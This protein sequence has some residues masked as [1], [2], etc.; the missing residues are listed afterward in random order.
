M[1][2][3]RTLWQILSPRE[4]IEGAIL[5]CAMALG[6][7]LEAVSI[8]L[9]VPFVAVLRDPGLVLHAPVAQSIL[10]ALG[11]REPRALLITFG[12]GLVAAF[13]VKSGYLLLIY[14]WLYRYIFAKQVA[15]S[16]Q[17]LTG[18][19]HAPYTFHLQRNSAEL[20]KVTTETI[21]R[22]TTGFLVSLLTLLGEVLVVVALVALLMLVSPLATSGA[23][24]ALG[25][26]TAL[27]YRLTQKRLGE[28]GRVADRSMA[29]MIQWTEQAIGGIK[30]TLVMGRAGFFID[31]QTIEVKRFAGSMNAM[32]FFSALPRLMIDTLAVSAMVAIALAV[33]LRGGDTQRLVPVL[34]MFAVAAM[35]LMPSTSRIAS[36]LTGIRFHHAAVEV[37]G[38]ELETM[39]QSGGR[40]ADAAPPGQAPPLPFERSLVL[41]VVSYRYPSMPHPA[42][43]NVSLEI[44]RGHWVGLI[45]PTGAGKTTLV[46]LVLG[47]FVA[48]SGEI[49]IDG[50]ELRDDVA[51]WQRNIGYVPQEI[52]LL[53]DTVRRNVAFGLA[54]PEINDERV[55]QALRAAQIDALVAALPGGLNALTGERGERL[56]GGERQRLGIAR[57]LYHDPQVLVVDEGTANLDHATEAAIV[58]TLAGLRG[59]KTI[60]VIAHKMEMVK[61][62]DCI[63]VLRHG[64]LHDWGTLAE[65]ASREPALREYVG[66]A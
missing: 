36:A 62:C 55:W 15:L 3:V 9:V 33:L 32:M 46:D 54:D 30:E 49:L 65:L 16:R 56:S 53:D 64:R 12:L 48:T 10:S 2:L 6:A 59:D 41:K 7:V 35:R 27:G 31:R 38:D 39:R 26:P 47:L 5:L 14:R 60:I 28:A 23:V 19:L 20:I 11:I 52:Y 25:I 21:Q 13:L 58:R 57:A 66:S 63:Y 43:D 22:F 51:R 61:D 40:G 34:G 8:G 4:R 1:Q 44:P 24:L 17:L 50:R 29:A 45:G 18:Y 37:L 42:V